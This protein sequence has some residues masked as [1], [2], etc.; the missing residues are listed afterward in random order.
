MEGGVIA[1]KP[2]FTSLKD[3]I[4]LPLFLHTFTNLSQLDFS[5][6]QPPKTENMFG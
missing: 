1:L 4:I 2:D 5:G 6:S 3:T